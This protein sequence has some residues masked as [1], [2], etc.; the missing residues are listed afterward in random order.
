MIT[1]K[2]FRKYMKSGLSSLR[3]ADLP[4]TDYKNVEKCLYT[5]CHF[6]ILFKLILNKLKSLKKDN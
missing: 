2:D 4:I 1:I 3:I 6:E 5:N